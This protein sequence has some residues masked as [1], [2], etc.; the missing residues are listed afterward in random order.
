[1]TL[2]SPLRKKARDAWPPRWANNKGVTKG[3]QCQIDHRNLTCIIFDHQI[4]AH[5]KTSS[6]LDRKE[7]QL[8]S[9]KEAQTGNE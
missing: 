8:L 7:L 3:I 2:I 5:P 4:L 1:M 9:L 6:F